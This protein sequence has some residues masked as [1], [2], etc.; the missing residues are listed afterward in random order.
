MVH[1]L[2]ITSTVYSLRVIGLTICNPFQM[3]VPLEG[4]GFSAMIQVRLNIDG[5]RYHGTT[6]TDIHGRMKLNDVPKT[7]HIK[8]YV[9]SLVC[10][11]A[12]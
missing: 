4:Q 10:L 6:N 5:D 1:E 2:S 7:V 12:P 11:L 9:V 3:G 8:G